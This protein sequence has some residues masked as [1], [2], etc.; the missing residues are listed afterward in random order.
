MASIF[1]DILDNLTKNKK[2]TTQSSYSNNAYETPVDNGS[3]NVSSSRVENDVQ[4]SQSSRTVDT[5]ADRVDNNSVV[6]N[7]NINP[8]PI[9]SP[10]QSANDVLRNHNN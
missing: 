9:K 4:A 5:F 6:N 7:V 10:P 1:D 8:R 3:S 2:T